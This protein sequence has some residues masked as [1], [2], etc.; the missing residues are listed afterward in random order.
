MTAILRARPAAPFAIQPVSSDEVGEIAFEAYI[1]AY[2]LVLCELTRRASVGTQEGVAMNRFSHRRTFPNAA[3]AD[4]VRPD[5]DT[6]Y[7]T[8]WFDV[9]KQ[10]LAISVPDSD[11]RYYLLPMLDMWSDIF[12]APGS[13]T[14]GT[15]AQSIVLADAGWLGRLPAG[16]TLIRSP[17]AV[18]WIIGRIQTNG[19]ADC[20]NVHRMQA[21]LTATP[22]SQ[23]GRP[24]D[25]QKPPVDLAW[26]LETPPVALI[27]AM[28]AEDY[29]SLFAELMKAN[30]PHAQDYPIMHRMARIGIIP[31]RSFSFTSRPPVVREAFE[32]AVAP[33]LGSIKRVDAMGVVQN[34]WRTNLSAIGTYGTDYLAR[35]RIAHSGL[36]ANQVEDA[37]YPSAFCDANGVPFS[38]E[39]RYV[40]HFREEQIP[41]VRAFWSLTLYDDRQLLAAN[42]LNR[43]AIGDRDHLRVNSDGSMDIY[44]QRT[45]PGRDK[46]SNWLPT[47]ASG[48]FTLNLRLYWPSAKARNGTW[49]PPPVQPVS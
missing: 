16:V 20:A 29:F 10:P 46:E 13:R 12:A 9:S 45:S 4:V 24:H 38:S 17:T 44:I 36:E 21:G 31:G 27:E 6:L 22:L 42:P 37:I 34:G 11:G 32:T 30:P 43:Y 15:R 8:L 47:P 49:S 1:Y 2:P 23:M 5:A 40:L 19:A 3:F 7:S 39:R 33:A 35:A 26:D 28:S 25:A 48:S 14:T 41:P 18:G